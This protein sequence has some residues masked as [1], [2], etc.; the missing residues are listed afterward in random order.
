MSVSFIHAG[1]TLQPQSQE[2]VTVGESQVNSSMRNIDSRRHSSPSLSLPPHQLSRQRGLTSPPQIMSH[3]LISSPPLIPTPSRDPEKS[4]H[5]SKDSAKSPVQRDDE[6]GRPISADKNRL[7]PTRDQGLRDADKGRLSSHDDT[8]KDSD[9]TRSSREP[10][11]KDSDKGELPTK[12]LEKKISSSK[13]S[14]LRE[15]EK[16]KP[17]SRDPSRDSEKGRQANRDFDKGRHKSRESSIRETEKSKST[18]RDPSYKDTDKARSLSRDIGLKNAEKHTQYGRETGKDSGQGKDRLSVKD[19]DKS[20]PP[21]RDSSYRSTERNKDSGS[22]K[23]SNPGSQSKHTASESKSPRLAPA[24]PGQ[25]SPP[26]GT[27]VLSG[28]QKSGSSKQVDK[29]GRHGSRDQDVS[30]SLNLLPRHRTIPASNIIPCKEKP[31]SGKESSRGSKNI[32]A[33]ALQTLHKDASGGKSGSLQKSSTRKSND[34]SPGPATAAA[35]KT[36]WPSRTSAE[37]DAVKRGSVNLASPAAASAAKDKHPKVK[38]VGSRDA[39]KDRDKEKNLQNSSNNKIP[40]LNNN[41][42]AT[43]SS[44]IQASNSSSYNSSNIKAP[45][46]GNNTRAHGKAQGEMLENQGGER[47]SSKGRE[48]Y[49]SAERK[50]SSNLDSLQHLQQASLAAEKGIKTSTQSHI[51]QTTNQLHLASREKKRSVKPS[52]P[53]PLKTTDIKT[54]PNGT[55]TVGGISPPSCPTSTASSFSPA[56]QGTHRSALSALFS[57]PSTSSS[58]SSE[59]DTQTQTE[60]D[61]LRKDHSCSELRDHHSLLTQCTEDEGDGP[62]DDHDRGMEDKHHEDDSDGSGSAKRRYPRRSARARSNM[63]FGLTPFYG[64]RSYGEQDLPFYGSSDGPGTMVKRRTGGHKK[65]AEGQVD[66]A[67]DMST[68]SSSGDSGDDEE[69][70]MKHRGKDPYYYNFT[71]T[72][73]NPGDGLPSIEGLDQCLGRGSQLQRFL[74][75]EEQQQQRAQEKS[76]KDILSALLVYKIL[77]KLSITICDF[78]FCLFFILHIV[79]DVCLTGP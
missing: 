69:S 10:G 49:S 15:T 60:E 13:D 46:L 30:A 67:D 77:K 73:I 14:G 22:G 18:P 2:A 42:K 48:N 76:E 36:L 75:D 12:K 40:L 66:G 21:S 4:K 24:G 47:S 16:V 65:S 58:D 64:V 51:K 1:V 7:Q 79:L 20:R 50:N 63:F 9:K 62:E 23:D 55:S 28:H 8:S 29:Q 78:F 34:Y 53:V 26:V 44:N 52:T 61:D 54:D 56:G 25:S 57:S 19:L 71:R 27:A 39:S 17:I 41:T 70:T 59:S 45:V 74:K 72:I 43:G 5:L 35:V 3:P 68:S 6:R 38:T 31:S 11:Q 37:D 33:S 32:I